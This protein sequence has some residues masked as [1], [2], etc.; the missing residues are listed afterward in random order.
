MLTDFQNAFTLRLSGK[1]TT[2]S[3]LD[4]PRSLSYVATLP[5]EISRLENRHPQEVIEANGRVRLSQSK[6]SFKINVW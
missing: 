4:I 1:F 2:N 6:N 3:Y 5:C